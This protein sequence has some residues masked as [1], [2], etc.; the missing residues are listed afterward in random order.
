M[1]LACVPK[2][3]G[4]PSDHNCDNYTEMK[5]DSANEIPDDLTQSPVFIG[6][7]KE[8]GNAGV[9]TG[10]LW[11]AAKGDSAGQSVALKVTYRPWTAWFW[12]TAAI[13]IGAGISWFAVVYVVRQRQMAANRI[14]IVRLRNLLDGLTQILG[15]VSQAGAPE[16]EKTLQHIQTKVYASFWTTRS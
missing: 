1:L 11:I 15:G 13:A 3:T 12:G 14:L 9:Y 2:Q 4:K 5:P 16:P 6:V 7:R 8:W 10:N